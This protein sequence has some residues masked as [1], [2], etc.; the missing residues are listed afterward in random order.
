MDH[1][2]RSVANPSPEASKEGLHRPSTRNWMLALLL[3]VLGR[4]AKARPLEYQIHGEYRREVDRD[5]APISGMASSFSFETIESAHAARRPPRVEY[6]TCSVSE[7]NL[8]REN[9]SPSIE[10]HSSRALSPLWHQR[11][12]SVRGPLR[13]ERSCRSRKRH[14]KRRVPV[15]RSP[16]PPRYPPAPGD[17][18]HSNNIPLDPLEG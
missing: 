2:T 7:R 16:Y 1:A 9:G 12:S 5:T 3:S 15:V 11:D 13:R 4:L 10:S 17:R 18:D 6:S 14:V 8:R